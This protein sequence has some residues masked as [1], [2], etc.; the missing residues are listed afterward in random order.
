MGSVFDIHPRFI[1][2]YGPGLAGELAPLLNCSVVDHIICH[3]VNPVLVPAL[4]RIDDAQLVAAPDMHGLSFPFAHSGQRRV[5]AHAPESAYGRVGLPPALLDVRQILLGY[6]HLQRAHG[7]QRALAAAIAQ[8]QGGDLATLPQVRVLAVLLHGH[9]EHLAGRRAVYVLAGQEG[10]EHPLFAGEPGHHARL[11]GAVVGDGVDLARRGDEGRPDQLRQRVRHAAKAQLQ[12]F[13]VKVLHAV[14][15]EGQAVQVVLRQ[16][17]RLHDA[18]GPAT[19]AARAVVEHHAPH[20]VVV[21]H[22]G[23][24]GVVFFRAGLAHQLPQLQH[25]PRRFSLART[26]RS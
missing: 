10:V 5:F 21:A 8:G 26:P 13:S 15:R 23:L 14:P 20:A 18:P 3:A 17:L 12:H 24:Q 22:R 25:P 4:P 11:D 19:G 9:V 6:A 1:R 2:A 7:L 16:V